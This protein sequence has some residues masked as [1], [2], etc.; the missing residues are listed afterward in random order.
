MVKY[1][2][3]TDP[4][5]ATRAPTLAKEWEAHWVRL[6][7]Q[8]LIWTDL[9]NWESCVNRATQMGIHIDPFAGKKIVGQLFLVVQAGR[10][11]QNAYVDIQIVLDKGRYLIVDLS[12]DQLA[13]LTKRKEAHWAIRPV[14]VDQIVFDIITPKAIR[15]TPWIQSLVSAVS[16]TTYTSYITSVVGRP[17]R[18][19]LTSYYTDAATYAENELKLLGYQTQLQSITVGSGSSYNVV[20]DR[21]GLASGSRN[22]VLITAHLDSINGQGGQNSPAPGADDNASGS[23]ALMEIARIFSTH[24]GNHDL[25]LILFG[26]EEQGLYGSTQYV[27]NLTHSERLRVTAVINMDMIGTLNTAMPTVLLEGAPVSQDL[28]TNLS[29]VAGTYTSLNVQ[30]SLNPFASDHVSFINAN[31]AAVLTI[32]GADSAN[33]NIHTAN[34][35]IDHIHYGLALDIIRLNT[36][37]V[38]TYI[39]IHEVSVQNLHAPSS[40]VVA[41]GANRLDTFVIGTNSSLYHK[42]WNRTSWGPSVTGYEYM[43]GK[44]IS[45]PEVVSW[46]PNRLDVFVLGTNSSLYHKWWNGSSWGPSVTGYEYMGGQI[47]GSPKAVSWGPNRLD[48]FVLGTNSAIYHKW[49]NGSTWGP[50]VTGYEYMGGTCLT[51]PTVVSWGQNRIDLFVIGTDSAL[52]HKWWDGTSWKPSVKGWQN[53]GGKILGVP[54]VVAWGPNRLDVFVLGTNSSLYHKWWDGTSWK[55]SISGYEYMGGKI[56]RF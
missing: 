44:I 29:I 46:G 10:V 2:V 50:S 8:T 21:Q 23:A 32:E 56:I 52:Y 14:P 54:R 35:T 48:V 22:L 36:A 33:S 24:S 3:F 20:A 26:G 13:R 6:G 28:M 16:Q 38:A 15:I 42:W 11:F 34:D 9:E 39:D 4:G 53:L 19:S 49:W 18:H 17:T 43:G 45:D 31:I 55:P 30:T 51:P 25:R 12:S 1:F 7:D 40:P 5:E 37:A 41:W 47:L 27:S